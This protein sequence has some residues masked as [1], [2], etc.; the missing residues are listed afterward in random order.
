[1]GDWALILSTMERDICGELKGLGIQGLPKGRRSQGPSIAGFPISPDVNHTE[2]VVRIHHSRQHKR[3]V[4]LVVIK[5]GSYAGSGLDLHMLSVD[6][7]EAIWEVP[8]SME[9][10]CY[11]LPFSASWYWHVFSDQTVPDGC[12]HCIY[13][14]SHCREAYTKPEPQASEGVSSGKISAIHKTM[15]IYTYTF[16]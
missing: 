14:A 16:L 8:E 10:F 6:C 5:Q 7:A 13:N 3:K 12:G 2:A 11:F 4:P 1:M 9:V 15:L